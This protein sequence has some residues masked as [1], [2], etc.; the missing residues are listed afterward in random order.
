MDELGRARGCAARKILLLEQHDGS[1]APGGIPRDA[2]A[3][4]AAADDGEVVD[5]LAA[6]GSQGSLPASIFAMLWI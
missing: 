1:A 3:V 6:D 4:H 5:R 2:A